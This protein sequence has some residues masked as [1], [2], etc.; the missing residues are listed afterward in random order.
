MR[1]SVPFV[2]IVSAQA[3]T[4]TSDTALFGRRIATDGSNIFVT[5]GTVYG[6]PVT[7]GS[8][9]ALLF[10]QPNASEPAALSLF[11]TGAGSV[12]DSE[13]SGG[14]AWVTGQRFTV[15]D[16]LSAPPAAYAADFDPNG[17]KLAVVVPG[18]GYAYTA[19]GEWF[20]QGSIHI[21]DVRTPSAP[22]FVK[23]VAIA[24]GGSFDYRKLIAGGSFI[25]AI[26]PEANRDVTI[27]DISNPTAPVRVSEL[28]VPGFAAFNGVLDGTTLYLAGGDGGVAVVDVSNPSAPQLLS[29]VDTPGIARSVAVSGPS[30]I[31]VAD[32]SGLTF[33]NTSDRRRPVVL[34]SQP[35]D[36]T[37]TDVK[38]KNGEIYV[39]TETR[40]FVLK[41]P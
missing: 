19:E 15:I 29:I 23:T 24:S 20:R 30:E 14:Y 7:A 37:A 3:A 28:D 10:R 32:S 25:Y 13:L 2:S 41:R 31:V 18:N 26:S 39:A 16:Y 4:S 12:L 38:V 6:T 34:G 33:I 8:T 9:R 11:D 40:F 27:I 22:K 5:D 17:R 1:G 21:Y 35:L 36:G